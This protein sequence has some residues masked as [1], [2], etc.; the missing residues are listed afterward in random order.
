MSNALKKTC[1]IITGLLLA[2]TAQVNGDD[3]CAPSSCCGGELYVK[4]DLL[5]W[6]PEL[7]G[8]ETAFGNTTISTTVV[9]GSIV[10]TVR[11]SDEEPHFKWNPGFRIGAGYLV[12]CYDI[13][14]N[15][16]HY[17]GKATFRDKGQHGH[18]SLKYDTIDLTIGRDFDVGCS[19][20]IQPYFGA[21]LA[22]IHHSLHSHLETQFT[23]SLIGNNTVFTE[24]DDKESFWG[25]GPIF[26]IEADWEIGCGF[27]A[28]VSADFVTYYGES[29]GKSFDTDTFTST[30]S[31]C[32]GRSDHCFYNI[33]TDLGLG[34][35]WDKHYCC[36]CYELDFLVKLGLEQHRIYNFGHLAGNNGG[37]L[38][39]DGGILEAGV[40]FKF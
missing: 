26:G 18:W 14:A 22:Q 9:G 16:T 8:L 11:E 36:G 6:R 17:R 20:N 19:I 40:G 33:A 29:K 24:K 28:Y 31:V 15:W 32:N 5:Y 1:M 2:M 38:S 3:C 4:A 10:T 21:R 13:E 39:L 27:S 7:C 12:D 34:V 30:S 35:R 37:N 25:L 23:S